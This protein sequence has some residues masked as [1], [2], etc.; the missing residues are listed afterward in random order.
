[1]VRLEEEAP[2]SGIIK[3]LLNILY[4]EAGILD[5]LH[6]GIAVAWVGAPKRP[7]YMF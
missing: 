6:H 3:I 2:L 5:S 1:M 4:G 7:Y